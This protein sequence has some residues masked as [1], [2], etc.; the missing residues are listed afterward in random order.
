[1]TNEELLLAMSDLMDVKLKSTLRA[2]LQPIKD[3]IRDIKSRLGNVESK[4]ESMESRLE[5]VESK[6]ARL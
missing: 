1:M 4:I 3:D 6:S 5:N 2:E